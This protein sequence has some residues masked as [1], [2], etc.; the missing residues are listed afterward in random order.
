MP[1]R[2]T[3]YNN[4]RAVGRAAWNNRRTLGR[5]GK[6]IYNRLTGQG[7]SRTP[8][9]H[10]H[11][12]RHHR[13]H[14]ERRESHGS[15]TN[16]SHSGITTDVIRISGRSSKKHKKKLLGSWRYLINYNSF[17]TS[18]AGLQYVGFMGSIGTKSQMFVNSGVG[19]N[20][21]QSA[22]GL[23]DLNPYKE[24]TGSIT[25]PSVVS[26]NNDNFM[27][28]SAAVKIEISNMSTVGA[29]LDIYV[30]TPKVANSNDPVTI[31]QSTYDGFG[32][33][34]AVPPTPGYAVGPTSGSMN[35][36]IP[37]VLPKDSSPFNK[38][39]KIVAV[40][41]VKLAGEATELID[42]DIM[43]DKMISRSKLY[44]TNNEYFA[45]QTHFFMGVLRGA[46]VSDNTVAT[47]YP[48]PG[49]A[50]IGFNT[51]VRYVAT[52]VKNNAAR[53]N[54]ALITDTIP[55]GATTANQGTLN[56]VDAPTTVNASTA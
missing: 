17:W 43:L 42:F 41:S 36:N 46:I 54:V 44:A 53:L 52:A 55:A 20:V 38:A 49:S 24:N 31:W 45:G 28:R 8:G 18:T 48:V 50:K 11:P 22:I 5:I 47:H 34:S 19:Y 9:N 4:W 33:A 15:N 6:R 39:F 56:E 21:Y 1:N 40:K 29:I 27:L 51:T 30:V 12:R 25:I 2:L 7:P 10:N 14:V 3:H 23:A 16:V 13:R 37:G 32:I 35:I 26:P